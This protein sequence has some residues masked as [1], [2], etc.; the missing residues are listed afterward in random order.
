MHFSEQEPLD[1]CLHRHAALVAQPSGFGWSRGVG[2]VS[3]CGD[4]KQALGFRNACAWMVAA[5]DM[6]PMLQDHL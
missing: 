2:C 1:V 6:H 4:H 5:A 3:V